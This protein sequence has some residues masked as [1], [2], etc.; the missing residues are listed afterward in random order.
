MQLLSIKSLYD[1]E[2]N[3]EGI[4]FKMSRLAF[5]D[6]ERMHVAVQVMLY[7]K[8]VHHVYLVN[9]VVKVIGLLENILKRVLT[10][11]KQSYPYTTSPK[12]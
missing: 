1:K 10:K 6:E 8:Q 11:K 5:V 9:V 2:I 12:R 7:Q 3:V 4:N